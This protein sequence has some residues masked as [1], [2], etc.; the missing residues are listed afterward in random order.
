MLL[1]L[2]PRKN[3]ELKGEERGAEAKE[4]KFEFK[5]VAREREKNFRKP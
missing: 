2:W 5:I 1:L 3:V 4:E